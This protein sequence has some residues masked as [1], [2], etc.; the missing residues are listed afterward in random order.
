MYLKK[1]H[2]RF[3]DSL[4]FFLCPLAK[5][6]E[7][8]EIDTVKGHFPHKFNTAENQNYIGKIPSEEMFYAKN[9]KPEQY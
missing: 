3:I 8:F 7:T 1:L 4:S 2:L 9:M 6:S 5:L